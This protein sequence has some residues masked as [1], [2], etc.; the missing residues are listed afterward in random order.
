MYVKKLKKNEYEKVSALNELN[1]KEILLP[2]IVVGPYIIMPTAKPYSNNKRPNVYELSEALKLLY[3]NKVLTFSEG[4]YSFARQGKTHKNGCYFFEYINEE[5]KYLMSIT[6]FSD[7]LIPF[8]ELSYE[9]WSEGLRLYQNTRYNCF[10][11]L[12]GDLHKGNILN[13]NNKIKLIDWEHLRS[14]PKEIEIGFYLCWDYLQDIKNFDNFET[15]INELNAFVETQVISFWERHRIVS[16]IIPMWF[17]VTLCYLNNGNLLYRENRIL[18]CK[19][20]IPTYYQ[21]LYNNTLY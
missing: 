17:L 20:V 15:F 8:F 7:E 1:I 6:K 2:N 14:G 11:I 9:M 3:N 4:I 19:K 18:A 5:I 13:Y 16:L 12:H 21:A 10:E